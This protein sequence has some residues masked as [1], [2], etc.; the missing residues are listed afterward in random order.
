MREIHYPKY[1]FINDDDTYFKNEGYRVRDF[2]VGKYSN[3][4]KRLTNDYFDELC[5][6]ALNIK[7]PMESNKYDLD[8]GLDIPCDDNHDSIK[9]NA[10]VLWQPKDGV[11]PIM[12]NYIC[13]KLNLSCYAFDITNTC[14]IKTLAKTR[15][16][17]ALVYY[18]INNHM[19]PITNKIEVDKL[20][21]DLN[22]YQ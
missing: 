14:F 11:S 16:Y 9:D 2:I 8:E 1:H 12:L 7:N 5:Y 20:T 17:D 15:H 13:K 19:Y 18:C 10:N 22:L 4:I 3:K 6:E 21:R